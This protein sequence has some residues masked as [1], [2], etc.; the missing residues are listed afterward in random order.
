MY[1]E[2][3]HIR[4][5]NIP[6]KAEVTTLKGHLDTPCALKCMDVE[7]KNT[8]TTRGRG[9]QDGKYR[10]PITRRKGRNGKMER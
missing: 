2:G 4:P 8:G 10:V 5:E 7:A 9:N 6:K 3:A 1:P